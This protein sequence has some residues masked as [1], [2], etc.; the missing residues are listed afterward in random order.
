MSSATG[1][2]RSHYYSKGSSY[3]QGVLVTF[4]YYEGM[5][6]LSTCAAGRPH[7]VYDAQCPCRGILD[8]LADKWS[9]LILGALEDGPMRFGELKRKLEGI[10]PKVLTSCLRRLEDR[11]LVAREIF[12]EVP[13]RVEYSLTGLGTDAAKPL[14]SLRD[15]VESNIQR[16]P[17]I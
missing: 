3:P 9:A 12:A 11:D 15:W 16:F 1:P 4:G 8:L 6:T 7:D 2:P 13:A 10:S 14:Q 17:D 5:T